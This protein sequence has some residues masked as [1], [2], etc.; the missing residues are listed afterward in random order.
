M[1]VSQVAPVALGICIVVLSFVLGFFGIRYQ[2]WLMRT[3]W[4]IGRVAALLICLLGALITPAATDTAYMPWGHG[5]MSLLSGRNY[6]W[7]Y[8]LT[9]YERAAAWYLY[10]LTDAESIY[11]QYRGTATTQ[12]GLFH[13]I[14]PLL[15]HMDEQ[16]C[17]GVLRYLPLFGRTYAGYS[18]SV[19]PWSDGAEVYATPVNPNI[20][21]TR[22]SFLAVIPKFLYGGPRIFVGDHN[23][24]YA[25]LEDSE[26]LFPPGDSRDWDPCS[27]LSQG[28]PILL[29][30]YMSI[31]I[32]HESPAKIEERGKRG[33]WTAAKEAGFIYLFV[34]LRHRDYARAR[35]WLT[36][37]ANGGDGE[38]M[39]ALGEEL[40]S[41][42]GSGNPADFATGLKWLEQAARQ[43]RGT[44]AAQLAYLYSTGKGTA[45]DS[46]RA[47]E[48]FDGAAHAGV[49]NAMENLSILYHSGLGVQK[50]DEEARKWAESAADL[51]SALGM[52]MLGIAY[53]SGWAGPSIDLFKSR[54]WYERAAKLGDMVA[55]TRLAYMCFFGHGGPKDLTKAARLFEKA[56]M[57]GDKYASSYLAYMYRLGLG[58]AKDDAKAQFWDRYSALPHRVSVRPTQ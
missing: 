35:Y 12:S 7:P 26:L 28:P 51:G 19:L 31:A 58:V 52:S 9:D 57:N 8:E 32:S 46:R 11:R 43:G 30:T 41:A 53:E 23:G 20:A 38:A 25:V 37:A 50:N 14:I 24:A 1:S 34:D 21:A 40:T 22:R 56:A 16:S 54:E 42:G 36:L 39:E 55:T 15:A 29:P 3:L 2:V 45:V 44:A 33:D 18:Y 13:A 49:I 17:F 27:I 47:L 4:D 6:I 10:A 5:F 48:L